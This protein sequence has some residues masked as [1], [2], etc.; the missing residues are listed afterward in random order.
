MDDNA[1]NPRQN[2]REPR[3]SSTSL[4]RSEETPII[5]PPQSYPYQYPYWVPALPALPAYPPGFPHPPGWFSYAY[6]YQPYASPYLPPVPPYLP[7]VH[8]SAPAPLAPSDINLVTKDEIST[9]RPSQMVI[10]ITPQYGPDPF[11][12]AIPN[13]LPLP[14]LPAEDDILKYYGFGTHLP[15]AVQVS[16]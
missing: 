15:P 8:L 5:N 3:Q 12:V 1:P 14:L 4:E 7:P 16:K 13:A 6:P 2:T 10:P 11:A 9:P